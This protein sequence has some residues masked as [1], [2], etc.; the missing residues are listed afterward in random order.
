MKTSKLLKKAKAYIDSD[1]K[2]KQDRIAN[3]KILLKKLKQKNVKR[4]EGRYVQS[5]KNEMCRNFYFNNKFEEKKKDSYL[6]E[7]KNLKNIKN[8]FIKIKFF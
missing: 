3:I 1:E 2:K 6:F 8:Q 7:I 5:A 4:V